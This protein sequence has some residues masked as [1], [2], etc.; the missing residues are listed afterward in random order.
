MSAYGVLAVVFCLAIIAGLVVAVDPAEIAAAFENV[1][2]GPVVAALAIVQL[3]VLLSALRW[4]FTA[5]RL[6]H[7][8]SAG[9]AVREYYIASFVNQTLPGGMAGDAVRAYRARTQEGWKRPA[10]AIVLERFSGQ[11]AFFLV[12]GA[13]LFVWPLVLAER[14]PSG[15]YRLVLICVGIL[16]VAVV[17][18][19]AIARGRLLARFDTLKPDLAAVFWRRG[20]FAIQSG[21][22]M[23]TVFSYIAVFMIAA[24]ATGAPLPPVAAITVIPLC[25]MT[26]LIPAGV[27][28]WGTREAA[29]AALWPLFGL[30]SAEGLSASLL[31]GLLSLLGVAPQGLVFLAAALR[32]RRGHDAR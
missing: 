27:G 22:S 32:R 9:L 30:T 26:M 5:G 13:G 21:L 7:A 16:A 23:L 10:A 28:G 3:Q 11:I 12:A 25:L 31:Y 17:L 6:G 19:L 20:A 8:I 18:G 14:L 4:R 1:S 15:F 2:L 29:A 24:Y